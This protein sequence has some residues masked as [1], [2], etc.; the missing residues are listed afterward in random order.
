MAHR[1]K[2]VVLAALGIAASSANAGYAQLAPPAGF[3]G[4]P[5]AW[6]IASSA[7]DAIFDRVI[8]QPNALKVPVPG[9]ATTMPASYR[10]AANAPR[11]AAAAIFLHP[12]VRAAVG[13]ATW[14][15]VAKVIWDATSGTWRQIADQTDPSGYQYQATYWGWE[16]GWKASK[17]AACQ[18]LLGKSDISGGYTYTVT[19]ASVDEYGNCALKIRATH[20]TNPTTNETT[21]VGIAR[22][23]TEGEQCP[24]GWTSSPAG[25]LSP[26]LTQPQM[27]ELL[28]PANQPGWP[29]PNTVPKELPPGTPLPVEQPV[30]NPAPGPNPTPRP[31]FVPTGDP[32]PNPNYSPQQYPTPE[33]APYLQPGVRVVPSPTVND[34]WRV[35]LQPL[36]RPTQEPYSPPGPVSDESPNPG[37]KPKTDEEQSLCEKHPDVVACQKLGTAPEAKPVP[38]EDRQLSIQPDTG[39]GEGSGSCPAPKTVQVH[40]FQLSMP[41]G[42]LCDFAAGIRPV[43]IGL[44]WLAA[45]FT[46]M[47]IGRRD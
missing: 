16:S 30:I 41:F 6:T 26:A 28:N 3:G 4:T 1:F 22:R 27:V 12:G 40:G 25:C 10:L 42:L 20:P 47:G 29:M 35:D 19:S 17:Q 32:V 5:G 7:N 38:N 43:V 23:Q 31:L 44:A 14:L 34:P 11:I 2:L 15:G 18:A 37:D 21:S 8:H 39:W 9:T 46:F 13:I 33:N 45:A 36:N 24:T